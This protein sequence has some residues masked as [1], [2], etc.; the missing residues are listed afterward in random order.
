MIIA[1]P[2]WTE[3]IELGSSYK[4]EVDT[5]AKFGSSEAW[6]RGERSFTGESVHSWQYGLPPTPNSKE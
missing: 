6:R 3:V 1:E 5:N 2:N 4:Q